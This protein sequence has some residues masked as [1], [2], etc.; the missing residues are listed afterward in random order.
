M[1]INHT[2][3]STRQILLWWWKYHKG[4][5]KQAFINVLVGLSQVGSGLLGI[6]L[7]RRMIDVATGVRSGNLPMMIG[8]FAAI[9]VL[10]ML[11]GIAASWVRAVLGSHTQN[12][13]QKM[14]FAR[15]LAS[16]WKGVEQFHSGD[17]LNRL[18][19]DVK[20][21]VALMTEL[22]PSVIVVVMQFVASFFY[23]Y[24]IDSALAIILAVASPLFMLL[25]RVYFKRMRRIVRRIKDTN[26]A[27]Q[28]VIQECLQ[29]KIIVK[30]F[31]LEAAM[32]NRLELRQNL[33]CRQI[34]MRARFAI[35]SK[36][37]VNVGF[38]GGFIV[39]LAWGLFRLQDN[40]VT[41]GVLMAF[42]QLIG[43]IQRPVLDMARLLPSL[44][45]SLAAS[46]RLME[47]ES[48][49]SE[50]MS[51]ASLPIDGAVGVCF[52]DVSFR[53]AEHGRYV[54]RG[55][56]Y[57]FAPRTFTAVF[58][59]TGAGKTTL[60]RLMLALVETPEGCV[61]LY[62]GSS[63]DT[64]V[65]VSPL[66]RCNFSYVPQGNTLFSGTIR[67][68]LLLGNPQVGDEELRTALH[69]AMADFVY[70]LPEGLDTRCG[71]HGGGLSEGQAQ[72][73]AIARALVHP[74]KVLLLDEAT[75]ALDAATECELL[76][77]I[78]ENLGDATIIFITH[79][80]AAVGFASECLTMP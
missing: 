17:I 40:L 57:N 21:I 70:D 27:L 7:M 50:T 33:L 44:V 19:G 78:K 64:F 54:L 24:S 56:S 61:S 72:R 35:F 39:A 60:V 59:K 29:H 22:L 45:N 79:R 34:K 73:I 69:I 66:T 49:P 38:S 20:D 63:H 12:N 51:T 11:L 10:E 26:S 30:A 67:E 53:Y 14:F 8:G 13:M 23:L 2:K 65:P 15:L 71:E 74:C 18:F 76:G 3:Y 36:T 6:D 4:C 5:R 37:L 75:S 47:L 80:Q 46:E 43:R 9:L 41:V 52:K 28:S 31:R 42:V 77:R 48:L 62:S 16:R 55:F 68:N 32:T 58:G 25:S 1:K